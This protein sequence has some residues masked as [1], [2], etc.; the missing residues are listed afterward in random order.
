MKIRLTIK[1]KWD[2]GENG[3]TKKKR[4]KISLIK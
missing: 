1:G 3:K 4:R 2:E